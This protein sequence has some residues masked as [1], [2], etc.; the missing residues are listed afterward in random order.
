MRTSHWLKSSLSN[1]NKYPL[2]SILGGRE[3]A[4]LRGTNSFEGSLPTVVVAEPDLLRD[5]LVKDFHIFP[6]RRPMTTGDPVA[7]N[8]VSLMIGEDWKRVRTIITPAFTSKRM[9]QM[10]SIIDFFLFFQMSSIIDECSK[11]VVEVCEEYCEKG[12]PVD[13]KSTFG[14]FTMDVIAKSAFGTQINSHK[15]PQ[16]EF[17][18]KVRESFLNF[19]IP[20]MM[21]SIL[22]PSWV[23]KCLPSSFNP[24]RFD[25]DNFF[26][27]V[28]M[29]II[30]K[31]RETGM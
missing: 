27:E 6:Y 22:L 31:R 7:D 20:R 15:D 14:A 10:S 24:M 4:I 12:K 5:I 30:K 13:F 9:R 18:R 16:N 1:Q 2:L 11:S 28:T 25:K 8:M 21:L 26:R 23:L 17:V 19:T 3:L 29:S